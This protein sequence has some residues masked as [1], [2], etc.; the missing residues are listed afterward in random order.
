[1]V[2]DS[3]VLQK[4]IKF[5]EADK[6]G[7]IFIQPVMLSEEQ[8][9]T[10]STSDTEAFSLE[11]AITAD[12]RDAQVD[13]VNLVLKSQISYA[14]AAK[15]A[16]GGAK[17]F[18]AATSRMLEALRV[19][20]AKRLEVLML[21]GESAKGIGRVRAN[22]TIGNK[23]D[24]DTIALKADEWADG[25]WA[26]AENMVIDIYTGT[27][28]TKIN[29]G[30]ILKVDP[31][32]KTLLVKMATGTNLAANDTIF[33][34]K[35][36][37]NTFTGI[38]RIL[39]AKS[40]DLFNIDQTK[41]SLWA[42]NT[43]AVG[44]KLTV[45]KVLEAASRA[46]GRG[47]STDANLYVN[48]KAYESL[49]AAINSANRRVDSSY[50]IAKQNMGSKM[51]CVNYQGGTINVKPSIYVKESEGYLLPV[52]VCKRIGAQDVSFRT[53][54]FDKD[55]IFH[56]MEANLGYAVRCYTHQAI[57]VEKPAQC[58]VLTG[59]TL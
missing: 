24:E 50:S 21:Y 28:N 18:E 43:S 49:N 5:S 54:G 44:G 47:L 58:V 20:V 32:A 40:T 31:V 45:A 57:F 55:H 34:S 16:G 19:S 38:H 25:I 23:D 48:H 59:I 17:S 51:I 1:M 35:A 15:A 37:G 53:P 26:G 36:K 2:P 22:V 10:Y 4:D 11:N 13:G 29:G 8:G 12:Y 52:N 3:V 6:V 7:D 41:Y 9:F 56:R 14:Q 39:T 46:V 42:G 30:T 33:F 27:T